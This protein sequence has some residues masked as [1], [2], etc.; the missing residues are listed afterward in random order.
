MWNASKRQFFTSTSWMS[1]MQKFHLSSILLWRFNN[2][3]LQRLMELWIF[4]RPIGDGL[5]LLYYA[6][7]LLIVPK[8]PL[9][10]NF[11]TKSFSPLSSAYVS[12]G[13]LSSFS[14]GWPSSSSFTATKR[15]FS[16]IIG[17]LFSKWLVGVVA[18]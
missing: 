18:M 10:Q 4:Q 5:N 1:Y 12:I 9:Y 2:G 11:E 3:I 14:T 16:L 13:Y 6:E 7:S 17:Y 15:S 8:N